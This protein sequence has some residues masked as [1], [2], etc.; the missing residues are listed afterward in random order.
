MI[1]ASD[2]GSV[3]AFDL[4][5]YRNFRTFTSE[6]DGI[7][8]SCLAVDGAGEVVVAG[9][10][11]AEYNVYVWSIQVCLLDALFSLRWSGATWPQHF[12]LMGI[13]KVMCKM[14]GCLLLVHNNMFSVILVR[15][16]NY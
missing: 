12:L 13:I 2:D 3:R 5:R 9:S 10:Q 15:P 6:R 16:E 7:Q 14:K 8:F 1:S 4:V 11:G